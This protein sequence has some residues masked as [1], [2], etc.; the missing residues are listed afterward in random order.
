VNYYIIKRKDKRTI[1][2]NEP[3]EGV[4]IKIN[5]RR[6]KNEIKTKSNEISK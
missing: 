1:N 6:R 5:I 4:K 3:R 2:K